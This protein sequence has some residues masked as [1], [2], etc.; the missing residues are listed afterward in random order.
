M[1]RAKNIIEASSNYFLELLSLLVSSFRRERFR[2][3]C[4]AAQ[5]YFSSHVGIL[6]DP[7]ISIKLSRFK[8]MLS[9]SISIEYVNRVHI[10]QTGIKG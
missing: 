2:S 3:V 1:L 4:P 7:R 10:S 6:T 8:Y 9:K 5:D